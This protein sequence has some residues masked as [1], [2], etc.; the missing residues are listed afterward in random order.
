MCF[1]QAQTSNTSRLPSIEYVDAATAD[2]QIST[3]GLSPH[4]AF[5]LMDIK[6]LEIEGQRLSASDT[7]LFKR[8]GLMEMSGNIFANSFIVASANIELSELTNLGVKINSQTGIILTALI[9]VNKIEEIAHLTDV[10]LLQIGEKGKQ[11]MDLARV[12]TKVSLVHQGSQLPQAYFGNNVVVGIIDGGFDYTHPN[13]YDATGANY[14]IKRVWE[15]KATSGTPPTGF[16][17]G[18]ELATQSNILTAQRDEA[19]G[20]HG[21]HVAGAAGGSGGGASP[22]YM[23]VA[24]QSDLVFVS[25]DFSDAAIADGIAY[26]MDYANSVGKPCVINMS[27]GKHTGPHDGL[28]AFDQYC[29]GMV[30]PGRIL[31]GSAGN[32]G[33][34]A[35][36]VGK[37]YTSSDNYMQTIVEFPY[38]TSGTNGE[39]LLDIWGDPNQNYQVAVGVYDSYYNEFMDT[40]PYVQANSTTTAT[41]TL[42]DYYNTPCTVEMSPSHSPLNNKNN[43]QVY[44]NNTAQMDPSKW[45]VIE[46]TATT[47]KTYMWS[48]GDGR[49]TDNGFGVPIMNGSSSSTMGELGG[50]G[51]NMITVGAYT[52]KNSWTAFNGS[53]QQADFYAPIGAIAPFSS[54]GPTADNRTKPD[55]TGPGNVITSSVNSFDSEYGSSSNYVVGGISDGSNSWAFAQMQGTSMSSPMVA[56]ILALW[57]E[58]YPYLTPT[59][60]KQLF[61]NSSRTDSYTGSIGANGSNTWGWGKIDAHQGLLALNTKIPPPPAITPQGDVTICQGQNIQL[62]APGGFSAYQWSD[63]STSQSLNVSAAGTYAVMVMNSDGYIS[64]WSAPKIVS[65]VPIPATPIVNVNGNVLTS[66]A[67]NGNQWYLNNS[68]ISGATQQ[69]YTALQNGNYHVVVSSGGDCWAQS[70]NVSILTVGVGDLAKVGV[71]SVYPNPTNGELNILFGENQQDVKLEIYDV[72]GRLH[73]QR[74]VGSV[75]QNGLETL[76]LEGLASG[77]YTLK[78]FAKDSQ[79][80]YRIVLTE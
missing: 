80:S 77:I 37:T 55:I 33:D 5:L 42:Y 67:A 3:N 27:L 38:A 17:Y 50:T 10:K 8:Y 57:L 47:G 53:T 64:P 69:S 78:V 75:G 59:Q 74:Q 58:A 19:N 13:F 4:T 71:S 15:Q 72:S 6:K 1:A 65:V 26:I 46:I 49:F 73:L 35:I 76:N 16:S 14:R 40:T 39:A 70:T 48:I 7:T 62:S 41:Y 43:V 2:F 31:V 28:S 79:G 12:E 29:D 36:Y 34:D 45:V 44:I 63:N 60:A 32:E 68:P 25:S 56:G 21:T 20:S 52:T 51:N 9:P 22:N 54:K 30:G 24:P 61:K 11:T 66:S 18:R 23:G